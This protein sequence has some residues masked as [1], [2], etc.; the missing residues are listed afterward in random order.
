MPDPAHQVKG[1]YYDRGTAKETTSSTV[2]LLQGGVGQVG[3]WP[4]AARA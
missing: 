1:K 3:L 4:V 2:L